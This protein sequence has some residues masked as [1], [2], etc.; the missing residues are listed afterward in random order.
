[1]Y[2]VTG[3]WG[4]IGNEGLERRLLSLNSV[5]VAYSV[6]YVKDCIFRCQDVSLNDFK[7]HVKSMK[8]FAFEFLRLLVQRKITFRNLLTPLALF[9][10]QK[11]ISKL[12]NT[13][14]EIATSNNNP[15]DVPVRKFIAD[16]E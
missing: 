13:I 5:I 16:V 11:Q 12:L 6:D 9:C 14:I 3:M 1:M 15:E 4:S 2:G 8:G 10:S 7:Q